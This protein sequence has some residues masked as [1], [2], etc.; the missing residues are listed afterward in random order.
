MYNSNINTDSLPILKYL[1][2]IAKE[3]GPDPLQ[4]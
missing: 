1:C 3:Q 2:I 4:Q